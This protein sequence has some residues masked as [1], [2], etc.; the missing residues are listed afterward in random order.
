[1]SR[2][3]LV[4]AP[5]VQSKKTKKERKKGK[6]PELIAPSLHSYLLVLLP[7]SGPGFMQASETCLGLGPAPL[8]FLFWLSVTTAELNLSQNSSK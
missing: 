4:T 5:T 1:M 2:S 6:K 8:L 3:G 7:A